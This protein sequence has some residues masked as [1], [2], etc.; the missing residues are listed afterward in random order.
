MGLRSWIH[1][2][3]APKRYS[4]SYYNSLRDVKLV[5][6]VNNELKMS[7]GKIAAQVGHAS[8]KSAL[9]ASEKKPA[10][11]Q[12]WLSSGQQKVVLKVQ[13]SIQ[14]EKIIESAKELNLSTCMIRD[15]GK[16][17]IPPNS[18]TVGGIGPASSEEIDKI[19]K[20]LKLL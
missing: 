7:K 10:E 18:L 8:V 11:M 5:C 1:S 9:F 13:N 4:D 14:L 19:T 6:I 3:T 12:A 15:A 2:L 16:T 17:Q 20:D